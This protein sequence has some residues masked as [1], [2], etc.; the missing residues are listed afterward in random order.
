MRIGI[1]GAT[2]FI[3]EALV[4][5]HL[6]LGNKVF[7]LSR[8]AVKSNF[9]SENVEIFIGDLQRKET[10]VD[11]VNNV[12]ILYHCAAEIKDE[13]KMYLTN[14]IGTKNLINVASH[15]VKH[16]IHLSSTGV[17][18]CPRK[19][20]IS[21]E[22]P[23]SPSNLYEQTKL[24]SD[25]LVIEAGKKGAFN[26]TIL[27]PSNVFGAQMRNQ[28]LFHL[29]NAI[30][31]RRFVFVGPYGASAN[32]ISVENVIDG[33]L[34]AA[35]S[36]KALNQVYILSDYCT[37]EDFVN[38]IV[39]RLGNAPSK[40]RCPIIFMNFIALLFYIFGK[41]Y[42]SFSRVKALSNRSIY[43]T[44]K[45]RYHLGYS[46]VKSIKEEI[47]TLVDVYMTKTLSK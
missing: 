46:P 9:D 6:S 25:L 15:V 16:W 12:D 18:G 29:I 11:F 30:H 33:M 13:S 41:N 14:V 5:R 22:H 23:Y 19:G 32:Y 10:L 31:K 43:C 35:N 7:I 24:E 20:I 21:E 2:G 17:Y 4:K 3:G 26:Y 45:V 44:E 1:T 38:F 27:R 47:E 39:I 34:L 37:L 40:M 8:S 42:L 28:S 36:V